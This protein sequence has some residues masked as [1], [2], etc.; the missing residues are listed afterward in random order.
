[1]LI[2]AILLACALA[3]AMYN[4]DRPRSW[5]LGLSIYFGALLVFLGFRYHVGPDWR[6]YEA[7]Y[8]T[9]LSVPASELTYYREPGFFLLNKVCDWAGLGFQGVVFV[10]A[11]VFLAGCFSFSRKTANP[12]MSVASV[13]PYLVYVIAGSG[14]RQSAAIG[15]GFYLMAN[16]ARL[17]LATKLTAIGLAGS[18]H[19]SAAV[20]LIF[21][22]ASLPTGVF[23]R[24]VMLT[25]VSGL[26]IYVAADSEAVEKYSEVYLA[27]NVVS[28]GAFFHV[29]LIAFPAALYLIYRKRIVASV[30]DDRNVH[31]ASYMALGTVPLL[32]LSSTGFDRLSLYL[33]FV[34]MWVYP[35]LVAANVAPRALLRGGFVAITSATFLVYFI[36]GSHVSAYVPYANALFLE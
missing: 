36:F 30:G 22:V 29:L 18:I 23:L 7:I 27:Q 34:Q 25:A 15:I 12:W 4:E 21:V 14:L 9:A 26:V 13:L 17:S 35:A 24:S 10:C 28:E 19:N 11:T 20:L 8:D 33:S 6:A 32:S 31:L 2:Y 5:S 1:M 3:A 16:V